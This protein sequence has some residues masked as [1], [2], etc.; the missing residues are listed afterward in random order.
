MNHLTRNDYARALQ[1][2]AQVEP[3]TGDERSFARAV[4]LASP[5]STG[6]SSNTRWCAITASKGECSRAASQT[7]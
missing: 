7:W 3:Q 4:V 2:L 5:A 6:I 1:L